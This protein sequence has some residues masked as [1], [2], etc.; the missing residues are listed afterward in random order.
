MTPQPD[1][2]PKKMPP[3]LISLILAETTSLLI[4]LALAFMPS[5]SGSDST[6]AHFFWEDPSFVQVALIYYVLVNLVLSIPVTIF[7]I[8]LKRKA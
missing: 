2:S 8:M 4:A 1:P 7:L 6:L 3:V 5:I